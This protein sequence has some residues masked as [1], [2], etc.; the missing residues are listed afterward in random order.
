M[1]FIPN[2]SLSG[3]ASQS[4]S[5]SSVSLRETQLVAGAQSVQETIPVRVGTCY[6]DGGSYPTNTIFTLEAQ[7]EVTTGMT[8]RL[9][10]YNLTNGGYVASYLESSSEI[11]VLLTQSLTIPGTSCIYEL[12]LWM[13]AAGGPA[14]R[15]VCDSA[16]IIARWG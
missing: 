16:K 6:I 12:H 9:R 11:P 3:P 1:T 14:A 5:G 4:T 10:L 15:V 2:V 8:A 13:V 7:L